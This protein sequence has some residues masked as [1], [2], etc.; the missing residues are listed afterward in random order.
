MFNK[1]M[2]KLEGKNVNQ[3]KVTVLTDEVV[4]YEVAPPISSNSKINCTEARYS[5]QY[6]WFEDRSKAYRKA[7]K[8]AKQ[9]LDK[10]KKII[11][12]A[13]RVHKLITSKTT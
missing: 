8:I 11:K 9:D 4:I 7:I 13:K 5:D 1:W 10:I 2:Y 6:E 3:Y 12:E